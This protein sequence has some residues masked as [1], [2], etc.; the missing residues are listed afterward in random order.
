MLVT[1]TAGKMMLSLFSVRGELTQDDEDGDFTVVLANEKERKTQ[2]DK[3][4]LTLYKK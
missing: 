3:D 1:V 2:N 4:E